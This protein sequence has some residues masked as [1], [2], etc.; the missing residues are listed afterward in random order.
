MANL[1][2]LAAIPGLTPT[3]ECLTLFRLAR[4]VPR[5]QCIVEIGTYK[6]RSAC[7]LAY[8]AR[9]GHEA[10]VYAIDAWALPGPRAGGKTKLYKFDQPKTYDEAKRNVIRAGMRGHITLIND[11]SE[12]A[13]Q[14][15]NGPPVGL[16]YIDGDHTARAVAADFAAWRPHLTNS[17]V[18]AFDDYSHPNHPGVAEVVDTLVD[19]GELV[20]L[21]VHHGRLAVAQ[22]AH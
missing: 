22:L 17:A 15:W 1:E 3:D 19:N 4:A 11:W 18:V 2:R 20:G 12:H 8:G 6:A 16:L 5:S 13:G 9:K 14:T 7:Y 10:H 21:E